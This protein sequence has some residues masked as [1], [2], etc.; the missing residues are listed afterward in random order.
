MRALAIIGVIAYH[1]R[2]SL[3]KGGLLGVTLFFVMTGFFTTRS[4]LRAYARH[5]FDFPRTLI[6]RLK[7]LWPAVLTV[8]ALVAPLTYLIAPSLLH[9][10]QQDA[11]PSALFASNWVYIARH[12]SYFEAAGLP[13]PL[14]HLWYTSLIMQFAVVWML[15][16]AAIVVCCKSRRMR[17]LCV[18]VLIVLSTSEMAVLYETGHEISRMY[19]GL[20]T[21]A[22]EILVGALLA[23]MMAPE[24]D[25]GSREREP[26]LPPEPQWM[27]GVS[28][29]VGAALLC[30]IIA[31][32]VLVDGRGAGL[33]EGGFLLTAIASAIV[34]WTCTKSTWLS[35][36]L[37]CKPLLYLGSRSFSLYLVH[38]PLLEFMNPAT[39]VTRVQWWEW[40]VQFAIIL[41]VGELFYQCIEALR[42]APWLPWM[43]STLRTFHDGA[44][45][46]GAIVG[47][48]LGALTALVLAFAPVPW[49]Q[50]AQTRAEQLRPELVAA[51]KA[52]P[53]AQP[54]QAPASPAPESK[55]DAAQPS[56][57]PSPAAPQVQA[58][59][60]PKNLQPERWRC[61]ADS[62]DARV[63]IVGD[64]VTEGAQPVLQ[65]QFPNAVID[66]QVSRSFLA[67]I[68]I[69]RNQVAA[70]DPQL[71]IVALGSND[72]VNQRELDLMLD[73]VGGRP[74]YLITPRAPVEWVEPD[75]ATFNAYAQQH[76]NVGIIDWH[77][78]TAQHPEYLVDDGTHLTPAGEEG[79]TALIKDAC[80]PR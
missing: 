27:R 49:A 57:S 40:I 26:G 65:Q 9:K 22:A 8:V 38:Y 14:T 12:T 72:L 58:A 67:G 63:L 55:D 46:P 69:V 78:L 52:S 20:D 23:M 16:L 56:A 17:M 50:L 64:S 47:A 74:L 13:S 19:Y 41:I 75:V 59:I 42:G 51:A 10:V 76:D 48:V 15:V 37:G 70:H 35:R 25:G 24:S 79:F 30:G 3:L 44:L 28:A 66:A 73:A 33:Y 2:P 39:R 54:S 77:A 53:S 18:L 6:K 43:R 32:F 4:L 21:R 1:T 11:L 29:W 7:R 68:D 62:C 45:R 71:V 34:V 80:C 5:H 36:V 60:V 31:A 61:T